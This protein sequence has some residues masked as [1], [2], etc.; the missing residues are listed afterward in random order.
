MYLLDHDFK[1]KSKKGKMTFTL[2]WVPDSQGG[3]IS[4]DQDG[5]RTIQKFNYVGL[6]RLHILSGNRNSL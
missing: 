2:T 1:D 5:G 6:V 3:E 4:P